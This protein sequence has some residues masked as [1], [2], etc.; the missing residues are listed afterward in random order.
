M[1][2]LKNILEGV[3]ALLWPLIV[4]AIFYQFRPLLSPIIE[5]AKTRKFTL[6]IGGQ[7]LTMEEA[8]GKV[9]QRQDQLEYRVQ[10]LQLLMKG[11]LT[12][13][14]YEKLQG[15][16]GNAPFRVGFHW[17]MYHELRRL[18]ALK[19]IQPQ[20]GY[21]IESIKERDGSGDPFDLKQYV[22]ITQEGK[23]YLKLRSNLL[24]VS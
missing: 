15:L 2:E 18:D 24:N 5:S 12:D 3:A 9:G 14:E 21:G 11:F 20:Q 8:L 4:I 1:T 17:D 10:V 7:E 23:E 19:Y 22:Y 16:A 13:F 6:K